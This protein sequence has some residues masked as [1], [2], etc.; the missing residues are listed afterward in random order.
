MTRTSQLLGGQNAQAVQEVARDLLGR[1]PG[2]RLRTT[3][4]YA[5]LAGVGQGTVQKALRT[6]ESLDA[7]RVAPRGHLGTYLRER[8]F[9]ALWEAAGYTT[10]TGVLPLPDWSEIEGMA[11]ALHHGITS[12]GIAVNLVHSPASRRRLAEVLKGRASFTVMSRFVA[13]RALRRHPELQAL[14]EGSPGS[15]YG[16]DSLVVLSAANVRA[17]RDVK[18]VAVDRSSPNH[19]EITRREFGERSVELVDVPY[20]GIP[21]AILAGAADA[22]AWHRTTARLTADATAL[23]VLPYAT[24]YQDTSWWSDVSTAVVTGRRDEPH[25]AAIFEDI[26]DTDELARTQAAVVHGSVIPLY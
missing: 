12:A 10:V 8:N 7:I 14:L 11:T 20:R 18:R 4:E 13:K 9:A 5:R 25:V 24:P 2:E 19:T 26:L 22:A 15:Y 23:R 21:A 16:I 3:T 1:A 6:L 17:Y